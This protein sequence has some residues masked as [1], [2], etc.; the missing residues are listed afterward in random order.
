MALPCAGERH[1]PPPRALHTHLTRGHNAAV[2]L[3]VHDDGRTSRISAQPRCRSL[4]THARFRTPATP[5]V[6][7]KLTAAPSRTGH[8]GGW[9]SLALHTMAPRPGGRVPTWGA[10]SPQAK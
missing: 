9:P 3:L 1:T 2:S 4:N 7:A 10:D 5:L 8:V 6:T